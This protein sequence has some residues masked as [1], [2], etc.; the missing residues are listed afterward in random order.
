[1]KEIMKMIRFDFITVK[2]LSLPTF[3][4]FF[5]ICLLLAVCGAFHAVLGVIVFAVF[6]SVFAPVQ[7]V[8]QGDQR[9]IYGI[10]PV[11]RETVIKANFAENTAA[12][13]LGEAAAIV[14]TVIGEA[15]RVYTLLPDKLEKKVEVLKG[16]SGISM[17]F[18]PRDVMILLCAYICI[19]YAVL[20]MLGELE[21]HKNDIRNMVA[22][23]LVSAVL[24]VSVILLTTKNILPSP[25]KYLFP[26]TVIGEVI[27]GICLNALAAAVTVLCCR[28]TVKKL[29]DKEL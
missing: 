23:V 12:M 11:K 15:S 27:W 2:Q 17:S 20:W 18:R 16:G 8:M 24:I 25:E 5:I 4:G 3:L 29:A 9:R 21:E 26:R 7:Q 6:T 28:I 10:L 13:L 22:A 14:M 1:M 19:L